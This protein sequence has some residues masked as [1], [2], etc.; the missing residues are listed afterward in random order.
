MKNKNKTAINDR[1]AK[2]LKME[3]N[4]QIKNVFKSALRAIEIKYGPNSEGFDIIRSEILRA[5]N[6][7]I[8]NVEVVIDNRYLVEQLPDETIIFKD[9][10][11]GIGGFNG[12]QK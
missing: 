6:N 5:G 10:G 2:N 9:P 11:K 7:A 8:R 4:I 12:N 3:I 1:S